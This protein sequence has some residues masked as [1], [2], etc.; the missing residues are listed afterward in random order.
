MNNL[1]FIES[2]HAFKTANGREVY[3]ILFENVEAQGE[4]VALAPRVYEEMP[5]LEGTERELH[6][7]Q[8]VYYDADTRQFIPA[9]DDPLAR[10]RQRKNFY[11]RNRLYGKQ[12]PVDNEQLGNIIDVQSY[13]VNVGHGNCSILLVQYRKMQHDE[14][15]IWMI[16]CGAIDYGVGNRYPNIA[17]CF[18]EIAQRLNT[19]IANLKISRF[20]LTHWHYDHIS[21]IPF[22][23]RDGYINQHTKFYLNLYY[24]HSS[25]TAN[26]VLQKLDSMGAACYEPVI[27]VSINSWMSVLYPECRIRKQQYNEA[28]PNRVEKKMNNSSAVY[29][30]QF[31]DKQ[32]I[33]PGDLEQDGWNVFK[34]QV[35]SMTAMSV[36]DYYCVSHH[37]SDNGHVVVPNRFQK[38]VLMGRDRAYNGIY[39]PAVMQYW[40]PVLSLSEWDENGQA[41][42]AAVLDW[43]TGGVRYIY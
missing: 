35:Q 31:W 3:T 32:M 5:T 16:D 38:V 19:N 33:C 41:S 6:E 36:A 29:A 43:S 13:H 40:N 12:Y 15:Q 37:G 2:I 34:R 9:Y 23:I 42:R 8:Y 4:Q 20:F 18:A 22:L 10:T 27:G 21:G 28:V 26:E 7:G 11:Y 14:H 1:Y 24:A 39:S 25:R 17:V 30:F